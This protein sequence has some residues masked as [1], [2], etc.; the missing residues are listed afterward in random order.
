M[1]GG[2]NEGMVTLKAESLGARFK[3]DLSTTAYPHN[4]VDQGQNN[5]GELAAVSCLLIGLADAYVFKSATVSP[6][7]TRGPTIATPRLLRYINT[8]L[9]TVGVLGSSRQHASRSASIIK[10]IVRTFLTTAFGRE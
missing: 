9:H 6:P 2:G 8:Q 5:R 3:L 10:E 1:K 7:F 4:A